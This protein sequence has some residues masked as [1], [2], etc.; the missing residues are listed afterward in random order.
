MFAYIEGVLV[1]SFGVS[2]D[3]ELGHHSHLLEINDLAFGDLRRLVVIC[4]TKTLLSITEC[5]VRS[6]FSAMCV[7]RDLRAT[8][9]TRFVC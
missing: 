8:Y 9:L 6:H 2:R 3:T 4:I 5:I 7:S 1:P